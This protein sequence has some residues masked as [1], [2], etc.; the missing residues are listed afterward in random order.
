[1]NNTYYVYAYLR[2]DGT[3]YYIGKGKSRRHLGDHRVH[4][5]T[6]KERI[7]FLNE[8]LSES[9]AFNLEKYYIQKYGRKDLGTGILRNLT[10]GGEGATG[11]IR[12]KEF[13]ENLRQ[14]RT[15][16]PRSVEIIEKIKRNAV[17]H[18]GPNNGMYGRQHTTTTKELIRNKQVGRKHSSEVNAKKGLPGDKNSRARSVMTPYGSYTTIKEASEKLNVCYHTILNRIKSTANRF[19]EYYFI[20]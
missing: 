19:N 15:G 13:K 18:I 7:V 16:I 20:T 11:A 14:S 9:D 6:D 17:G 1:M 10:D 12:S 3:P 5:P 4:V 2:E 8:N